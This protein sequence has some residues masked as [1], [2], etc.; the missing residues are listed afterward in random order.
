[1]ILPPEAPLADDVDFTRLANYEVTGGSVK[2]AVF[3]AASRTALREED[4]RS[5]THHDLESAIE[6]EINKNSSQTS[7]ASWMYQ[8]QPYIFPIHLTMYMTAKTLLFSTHTWLC[9]SACKSV[10]F[11]LED[12][13]WFL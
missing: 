11:L 6:E 10:I 4:K 7:D 8:F 2:S 1:M 12:G 9:A 13:K 3:R 5:I